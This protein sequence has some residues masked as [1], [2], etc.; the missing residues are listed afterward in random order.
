MIVGSPLGRR[1]SLPSS[2][3]LSP[4][5]SLALSLSL[6]LLSH[7]LR[8]TMSRGFASSSFSSSGTAAALAPKTASRSNATPMT[9]SMAGSR[10]RMTGSALGSATPAEVLG[11]GVP[12]AAGATGA[13]PGGRMGN[14]KD[15]GGPNN[16]QSGGNSNSSERVRG[17]R[18]CSISKVD[19]SR[20][21]EDV[22]LLRVPKRLVLSW[23]KH[24]VDEAAP[25][26]IIRKEYYEGDVR[27]PK[28][29]E[30]VCE[31]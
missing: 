3:S 24:A 11:L 6:V 13:G 26:A 29:I 10:R 18:G 15:R 2:L 28:V 21:D 8:K 19:I 30:C 12:G 22:W 4:S 31:W 23:R 14:T 5:P 20:D 16:D 17:K 1:L 27:P 7:T 9:T 25:I